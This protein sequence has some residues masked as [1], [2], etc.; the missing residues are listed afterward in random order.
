MFCFFH[1][2]SLLQHLSLF[3]LENFELNKTK[4]PL[5]DV[6]GWDTLV[7][8]PHPCSHIL[9]ST[10]EF[11]TYTM[12]GEHQKKLRAFRFRNDREA[13]FVPTG[14]SILRYAATPNGIVTHAAQQTHCNRPFAKWWRI[15]P[16]GPT[17]SETPRSFSC[18]R[19]AT[20]IAYFSKR[21]VQIMPG[22]MQTKIWTRT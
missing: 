13:Q 18:C 17:V 20:P 15:R 12:N 22:L 6:C 8:Q 19:F 9:R 1:F 11:A 3:C 10:H 7:C 4:F 2:V 16:P 5:C 21:S 14:I